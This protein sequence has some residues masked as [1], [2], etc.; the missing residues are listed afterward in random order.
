MR[1]GLALAAV[2]GTAAALSAAGCGDDERPAARPLGKTLGGSV[3]PLAQCSDWTAGAR[4]RARARRLATIADI[5]NQV[6][7]GDTGIK[8]PPLSD[9]EATKLFDRA[10]AASYA[11]GFRL[12]VIYARAA[13]FAPLLRE[14]QK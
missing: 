9:A 1:G 2:L 4:A 12:Y 6:N 10:C 7:R 3:A 5:R 11:R 8:A 14:S 13:G